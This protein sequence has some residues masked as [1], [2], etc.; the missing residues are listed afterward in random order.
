MAYTFAS[1]GVQA[2]A[3]HWIG[4]E[5]ETQRNPDLSANNVT[6]EAVSSN[7]DDR[8]IHELY[9]WPFANAVHS[10]VASMMCVYNRIN[11]TYGCE[12]SKT[13]NGLLKE[14]LGFQGWVVSDWMATHSGHPAI[15][16]GLDM[17]MPG[18]LE[19]SVSVP[20]FFGG[21]IS[22]LINNGSLEESRLDDMAHR[23]MTPYFFLGQDS[24]FPAIDGD[25][26][27]TQKTWA[28][29]TYRYNFTYGPSHVDVRDNHA[30]LIRELASAGSVLL[31]N[32]KNALPLKSP[33]NIAVFGNDA[34]DLTN[35]EYFANL[36]SEDG[37]EY[38]VLPVAGGS[39]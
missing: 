4:N 27:S 6:I 34:A 36:V 5:Q 28:E 13:L 23:I 15:N 33:K 24:G 3:K 20:S 11:G 18:G 12:N 2:C 10:G 29:S 38:G 37:F 21:N 26:P 22:V 16:A 31:K 7:I 19:F 30:E 9:M 39:G 25:T 35:G 17:N 1:S 14:E 32:E 8:T